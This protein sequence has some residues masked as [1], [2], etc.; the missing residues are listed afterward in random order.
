MQDL[1]LPTFILHGETIFDCTV[2]WVV[3]SGKSLITEQGFWWTFRFAFLIE[4]NHWSPVSSK[5]I[6]VHVYHHVTVI[7]S[8]STQFNS[9]SIWLG[10]SWRY[11]SCYSLPWRGIYNWIYHNWVHHHHHDP[12]HHHHRA[13]HRRPLLHSLRPQGRA[14]RLHA[15]REKVWGAAQG[16]GVQGER[17]ILLLC[18]KFGMNYSTPTERELASWIILSSWSW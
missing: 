10:F 8:N 4:V 1:T 5:I 18:K 13:A 12:H 15:G 16:E 17:E 7:L 2:Q 9:C 11:P 3:G 14:R 6:R